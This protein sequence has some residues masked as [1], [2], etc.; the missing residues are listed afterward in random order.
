MK[1]AIRLNFS[2]NVWRCRFVGLAFGILMLV[3]VRS[4]QAQCSMLVNMPTSLC[5]GDTSIITFGFDSTKNVMVFCY[6]TSMGW[7]DSFFLPDGHD[8]P[9]SGCVYHSV[10][11]FQ[12][13]APNTVVTSV[14]DIKY[15]RV[16]IEHSYVADL[17]FDL[18]CPDGRT[19]DVL[20]FGGI[21]NT[22]CASHVPESSRTWLT[23]YN[24]PGSS[25]LGLPVHTDGNYCDP[26]TPGNEPGVG[27]NYCWSNNN[28]SGFVYPTGNSFIPDDGILYRLRSQS[29]GTIDSSDVASGTN[30]YHPDSSFA[31]LIGCPLNGEWAFEAMDGYA[32]DNGY[33]FE[34]ELVFD[35]TLSP[36]YGCV[37]DSFAMTG[38]GVTRIDDT[39]FF[40]TS[41]PALQHDTVVCFTLQAFN[42]C[43]AVFDTVVCIAFHPNYETTVDE[44]IVEN[45]LPYTYG[46]V[47]FE[48]SVSDYRFNLA[49]LYGCDSLVH[50]NLDVWRNIGVEF[51]TLVCGN[52]LPIVWRGVNFTAPE[53]RV[54][55]LN[56]VHGADSIVTL[57][58]EA[59]YMDTVIF[60]A[61]VCNNEP[62]TWIDGNTYIDASQC[63]VYS[64]PSGGIC[65]SVFRL[66][67]KVSPTPFVM[68]ASVN[69][70]PA[71]YDENRV[72]LNDISNSSW[73]QWY[74]LD[75]IDTARSCD[76]LFPF[77]ADSVEV[78]VMGADGFG[79]RDSAY[80]IVFSDIAT[81]WAPNAFTP[82]E[83][84]NNLFFIKTNQI[85]SGVVHMYDRRGLFIGSF[86]LLSGSWDGS[87]NGVECP[88]GA[89]VWIVDYVKKSAP[90]IHQK[91]TG[92]VILLR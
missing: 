65:D 55:S 68:Q 19:V 83:Q 43:G 52:T 6:P 82:D 84:S 1:R 47:V 25:Y 69:P 11:N 92:T 63:P 79:C 54:L 46:D 76:F 31:G 70:N 7:G 37:I 57:T 12:A 53:I 3:G 90:G 72:T 2:D 56:T 45:M 30:F 8:C 21:L 50:Y 44:E 20:R 77:P 58:M 36:A 42:D 64:F 28:N 14:N 49:S 81:L 87:H 32:Q 71:T 15:L 85:L 16:N 62:Y 9:G 61:F 24:V 27:W 33:V 17:Y 34:W 91:K 67:I 80:V 22:E 89:Y 40:V 48:D 59:E 4:L 23:G 66:R 88:Q 38:M 41:D 78:Y 60:E 75:R 18:R 35:P 26:N 73:R 10:V 51:D 13:F 74:F 39:S 29:Q 86:D 5:A